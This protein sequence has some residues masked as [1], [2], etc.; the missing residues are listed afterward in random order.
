MSSHPVSSR[1]GL[2]LS[3]LPLDECNECDTRLLPPALCREG[4]LACGPT[5]GSQTITTIFPV[6]PSMTSWWEWAPR[7]GSHSHNI[8]DE[9]HI[10]G[11]E[12]MA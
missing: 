2:A 7:V 6:C 9:R 11:S 1:P 10:Q 8:Y 3:H 5:A 12:G 4:G